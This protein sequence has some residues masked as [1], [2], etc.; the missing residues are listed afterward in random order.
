M[1]YISPLYYGGTPPLD[2]NQK[3]NAVLGNFYNAFI[4]PQQSAQQFYNRAQL[5]FI[6]NIMAG[7]DQLDVSQA[8]GVNFWRV[9]EENLAISNLTAQQQAPIFMALSIA[10]AAYT[11][12]YEEILGPSTDWS[13]YLDSNA[14]VNFINFNGWIKAIFR[15]TLIGYTQS[16]VLVPT[17]TADAAGIGNNMV[18]AIMGGF[19]ATYGKIVLRWV[20]RPM[21]ISTGRVSF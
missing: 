15:G 16:T 7:L 1:N 20:K 10:Q 17:T 9:Q 3:L 13:N 5:A 12:F 11:Y 8:A 6:A 19:V 4:Q 2:Q 21:L 14:A 18:T